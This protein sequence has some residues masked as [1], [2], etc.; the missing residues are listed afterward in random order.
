MAK[1]T[2]KGPNKEVGIVFWIIIIYITIL[3]WS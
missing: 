3:A 2:S 1:H